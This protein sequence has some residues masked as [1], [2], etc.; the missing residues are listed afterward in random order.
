MLTKDVDADAAELEAAEDCE[1]DA[2][3]ME[4]AESEEEM[5]PLMDSDSNDE[6]PALIDYASSIPASAEFTS[7]DE[8]VPTDSF[9]LEELA[10]LSGAPS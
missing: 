7:D 3:V 2:D 6:I 1:E 9:T 4:H 8:E 5:P 10:Q